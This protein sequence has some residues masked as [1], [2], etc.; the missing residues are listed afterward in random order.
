MA[1]YRAIQHQKR[2]IAFFSPKCGCSSIKAWLKNIEQPSLQE[3]NDNTP[4][5]YRN[6]L[7][8]RS[9]IYD[10]DFQDYTKII[11][12]RDPLHRLVSFYNLF[13]VHYQRSSVD[14]HH[15]DNKKHFDI[16]EKTFEEFLELLLLVYR[17]PDLEL[18]HHLESQTMDTENIAFD[19]IIKVDK[20][21]AGFRK[22]NEELGLS[23]PVTPT[24]NASP[25]NFN[26]TEYAFNKT[27]GELSMSGTPYYPYFYNDRL[28]EIAKEVYAED[29]KLYQESDF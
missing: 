5:E 28:R 22:L 8:Y 12:V 16:K 15:V 1:F 21:S 6:G 26:L 13:V 19:Y 18:Q 2:F 10:K 20:L 29:F 23:L 7:Q 4:I 17:D 27:P 25:Y 24:V 14:W 11:F 3:E 9:F